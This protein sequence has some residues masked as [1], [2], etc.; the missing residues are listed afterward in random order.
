M[1]Q[2]AGICRQLPLRMR[3]KRLLRMPSEDS[4]VMMF[5]NGFRI[6]AIVDR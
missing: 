2:A 4:A 3:N 1:S 5:D 6:F